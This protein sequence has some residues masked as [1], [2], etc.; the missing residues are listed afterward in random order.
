MDRLLARLERKLGRFAIERL[1][2]YIV[3]GMAMVFALCIAKPEFAA[4]LTLD[5]AHVKAGEVW[6]LV[7]YLF[8]P[9]TTSFL[10]IIFALS[11]T[12]FIGSSLEAE[13]GAFKYNVFYLIGMVGT[14]VAAIVSGGA[15]GNFFLNLSLFLAFATLFP[16]Y[17]IWLY[18]ILR[19]RAK[20]LALFDAAYLVYAFA[21]GDWSERAAIVAAMLNYTLFF[22]G[23]LFAWIR[24]K[25]LQAKQAARRASFRSSS[26]PP[27]QAG[28]RACAI[29]GA[30]QDDGAD[31]RVCSCDKCGGKP[32]NL[33]LAHARNH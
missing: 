24:G 27:A 14:T 2:L 22:S 25:N 11:L 4:K 7:T 17:E 33:C 30:R 20:W 9:P 26:P 21:V 29:C 1:T 5:I 10:W 31:I 16:E 13:W 19:I 12:Y 15:H 3:G 32:R 28:G 6:R 8:L 18:F 23:H